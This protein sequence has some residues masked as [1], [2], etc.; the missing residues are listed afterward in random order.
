MLEK[1]GGRVF[2][3]QDTGES[4]AD[5]RDGVEFSDGVR[6]VSEMRATLRGGAVFVLDRLHDDSL[7]VF[8]RVREVPVVRDA[9]LLR[10]RGKVRGDTGEVQRGGHTRSTNE[11]A[12]ALWLLLGL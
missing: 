9:G 2:L 1:A 6:T 8:G 7:K 5:V 4:P 10:A 11:G 12:P 3:L